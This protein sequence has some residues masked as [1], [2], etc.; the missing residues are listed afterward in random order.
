M[1]TEGSVEKPA[2]VDLLFII[3]VSIRVYI[4]ILFCGVESD[5]KHIQSGIRNFPAL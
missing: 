5:V 3:P 1:V 4:N 2:D